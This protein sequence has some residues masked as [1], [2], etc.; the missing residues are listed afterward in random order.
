MNR[1]ATAREPDAGVGPLCGDPPSN[2]SM[3]V[4]PDDRR[5]P[6][7]SVDSMTAAPHARR[8]LFASV[9]TAAVLAG[10]AALHVGWGAGSSFP[11]ADHDALAD[12]V[13]G[14][15]SAPGPRDCFAVA[16][17]LA[18]AAG[19]V[20]DVLPLGTTVRRS[21]LL[22]ITLVLGGRGA[23]GVAGRTGTIVPWTP[24][25]RFNELD[26]QYYGPLCLLLAGGTMLSTR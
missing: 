5:R 9:P 23:L 26:K 25:T 21:G 4:R 20:A 22:G 10:I 24:S 19:V 3:A 13:A 15:R 2:R 16:A 17:L 12:T 7:A 1:V 11:F 18:C 14:S 8:T 6:L